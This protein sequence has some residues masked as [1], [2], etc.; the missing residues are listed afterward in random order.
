MEKRTVLAIILCI[1]VW[2][3]WQFLFIDPDA[4]R[5]QQARPVDGAVASSDGGTTS[6]PVIA[7]KTDTKTEA[8]AERPEE[9]LVVLKTDQYEA[10]WSSQGGGLKAFTLFE[11][12][13]RD[14]KKT[15][16]ELKPENLISTQ[17][18]R[19]RTSVIRFR[20]EKT[21]FRLPEYTDWEVV[22]QTETT[23]SFRYTAAS[24]DNNV[25]ITKT[26]SIMP[27]PYTL[28][29]DIEIQNQ[30]DNSLNE[31]IILDSYAT[32]KHIESSGC[33][34]APAAPRT[35][36]CFSNDELVN[37]EP[38]PGSAAN[39]EPHV[40]WTGINEQYFLVAM[41]PIGVEKAVCKLEAGQKGIMTASLMYPQ[42]VI[43]PGGSVMHNFKLFIGPKRMD[44][45]KQVKGGV[46]SKTQEAGLSE[47]VDYGW[48]SFLC[49]PMLWLLKVF[50]S[51]VGNYGVAIIFLTIVVK[52]ILL[53]LNQ[54]S[55]KSMKEMSKLKPMMD[56]LKKKYPDDKQKLNQE[57]MAMYKTNKINPMGGCFPMLL[58]MPI[59]IALYRMLYSS[60]ELYQTTFIRG[61]IDDMSF[62][63]PYY[64][65]PIVLGATMF[66]QQKLSPTSADSQQA[67]MMMYA[68]PVFFTFIMLYLPAGL[69]LYIFVNSLLSI[70]HQ[71]VY[72]RMTGPP[73]AP[74]PKTKEAKA[75]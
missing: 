6:Q 27:E 1:A 9:V 2:L 36:M 42:S 60:V 47:S 70:G 21:D 12:K 10:T 53:P 73:G 48:F 45:L 52:L 75:T 19:S 65:M 7:T 66:L 22:N 33:M 25:I 49:H 31:Q 39:S 11:Y 62:R 4:H 32:Y 74:G 44:L 37:I 35:P 30:S 67:K 57:M 63:D 71:L 14:E 13:E 40:F 29:L 3:I 46:G 15:R 64:I 18:E 50:F 51:L 61:W 16:G 55:M 54:K 58:Q 68:M 34:G 26:Y 28:D 20:A 38:K 17:D 72:N 41:V 43:P 69:V 23:V 56:D 24:E 59:W 5:Q 8:P